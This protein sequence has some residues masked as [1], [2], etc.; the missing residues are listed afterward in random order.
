MLNANKLINDL[1]PLSDYRN[2]LERTVAMIPQSCCEDMETVCRCILED[3][4]NLQRMREQNETLIS[5]LADR[6]QTIR[7]LAGAFSS[8]VCL[9]ALLSCS[10]ITAVSGILIFL[11]VFGLL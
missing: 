4:E 2:A 11:K 3:R 10:V 1:F 5:T 7:K 8:I 6:E 9:P